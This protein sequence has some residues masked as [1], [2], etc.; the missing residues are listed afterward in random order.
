MPKTFRSARRALGAFA[1]ALLLVAG[2][3]SLASAAPTGSASLSG[4]GTPKA[5]V[6]A[7][8]ITPGSTAKATSTM[9][10]LASPPAACRPYVQS[11][12]AIS[13]YEYNGDVQW[14]RDLDAN[15]WQAVVHVQTDYGKNR[16]CG[17]LPAAQGWGYCN[18]DHREDSCVRFRFYE[19]K[20]GVTRNWTVF[21]PYYHASTGTLC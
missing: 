3:A 16:Y 7:T 10:T 9:T 8:P 12:Y 14:I 2:A 21:S 11:S 20:D 13:C 17:A 1:G 19:L 5:P 15:G 6:A 4:D 18:Y